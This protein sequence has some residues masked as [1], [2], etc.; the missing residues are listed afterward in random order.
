[1]ESGQPEPE[2]S[3]TDNVLHA[4]K[5]F[6]I[7]KWDIWALGI[8]IVIGGQ[9]FSWNAGLV[10]GVGS[11]AIAAFLIGMAYV[12][13]C[14]CVSEITSALPFAGGAY[15]LAR[16]SLGFFP[17]FLIGCSET[18][19]Y[20]FY[21]SSAAIALGDMM[22]DMY[23]GLIGYEPFIW[24]AF[25]ISSLLIHIFGGVY[26]WRFNMVIA[27]VS[28]LIVVIYVLGSTPYVNLPKYAPIENEN[29][30]PWFIGGFSQFL[31]VLPLT[32]WFYVGIEALNM[33]SVDIDEPKKNIPAGQMSCVLTLFVTSTAVFLV[34]IGLPPGVSEVA[35]NLTPFNLGNTLYVLYSDICDKFSFCCCMLTG[36]S[37]M[38][39]TNSHYL[40]WL[41]IPAT[42]ATAFGFVY[43]YGK[44]IVA[45]AESKLYPS[46]VMI[47][48]P[49]TGAPWVA[50][51]IGSVVGYAACLVAYFVPKF[52][53]SL[54]N[55]CMLGG[56]MAYSAQCISYIFYTVV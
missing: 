2:L 17:G 9:Y 20:I 33:A 31:T 27:I 12:C 34:T 24:L 42:Y 54:F 10:A 11:Y 43:A 46:W 4:P 53:L 8:T 3:K 13:L 23:P 55:I 19:E 40:T 6:G 29:N 47:R 49:T 48:H 28:I 14:S 38:F 56:F 45:M 7:T 5:M 1:M 35:A 26:F 39:S 25:Y 15:G 32:A 30:D 21:V 44:M 52:F 37:K 36:F 16:C 41:N 50:L 22:K 18:V 51:T